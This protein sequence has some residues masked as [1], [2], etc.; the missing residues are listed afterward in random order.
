MSF[1]VFMKRLLCNTHVHPR[2]DGGAWFSSLIWL[3]LTLTAE[4]N[5]EQDNEAT[6]DE[7]DETATFTFHMRDIAQRARL[8]YLMRAR[9]KWRHCVLRLAT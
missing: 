7:A 1:F 5:G 2:Q 9:S 8:L 3:E 4:R 6:T